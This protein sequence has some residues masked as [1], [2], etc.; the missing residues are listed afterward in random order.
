MR[1][2]SRFLENENSIFYTTIQRID[3]EVLENDIAKPKMQNEQ[4][5]LVDEKF[6]V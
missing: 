5:V 6:L 2:L 4:G 3:K 1:L